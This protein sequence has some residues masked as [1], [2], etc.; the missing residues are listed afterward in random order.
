MLKFVM[1]FLIFL[2]GLYFVS[3]TTSNDV[4]ES[5]LSF[6]TKY[7]CPDILIKKG[8]KF[9]LKNTKKAEVPGVN[10]IQFDS[11]DDYVEY[12]K[13]QRSYNIN[14]PVLFF[15]QE[16]G[17]Q[18]E[19]TYRF[20]PVSDP[21]KDCPALPVKYVEVDSL[22]FDAGRNDPPFNKNSFPAYDPNNQYIGLSTPLD[23]IFH[24]NKNCSVNPHDPN[25]CG[26][27]YTQKNMEKILSNNDKLK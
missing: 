3:T 21:T 18:G 16:I 12:M 4:K 22:L 7:D 15:E 25:W 6:N 2:A 9:Y 27:E 1:I 26:A 17:T 24:E 14:C 8:N 13:W 10:P 20:R 5:F 19:N 23:K 11:L